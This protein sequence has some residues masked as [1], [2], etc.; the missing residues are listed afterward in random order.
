MA[1]ASDPGETADRRD[2]VRK[3]PVAIRRLTVLTQEFQPE[4]VAVGR[5]GF[6]GYLAFGYGEIYVMESLYYGNATYGEKRDSRASRL[7]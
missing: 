4:V 7:G 2:G 5:A 3:G 1:A 6:A